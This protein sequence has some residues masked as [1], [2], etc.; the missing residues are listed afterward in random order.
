MANTRTQRAGR[1]ALGIAAAMALAGCD[2]TL[3]GPAPDP[4]DVTPRLACGE[5]RVTEIRIDGDGFSPMG[6]DT[7]TDAPHLALPQVSLTRVAALDGTAVAGEPPVVVPNDAEAPAEARVRWTDRTVLAFDVFPELALTPGLYEARVANPNG[8]AATLA[9]ALVIVPRPLLDAIEPD[10]TCTE[11]G[12]R[13]F[14]I[15]GSHFLHMK[16]TGALPTVTVRSETSGTVTVPIES[17]SDCVDLPGRADAALCRSGAL[18]LPQGAPDPSRV[19][20]LA[21]PDVIDVVVTNPDPGGCHSEDAVTLALVPPPALDAITPDLA[22]VAQGARTLALSGTNL[23]TVGTDA[24]TVRI[25]TLE[26]DATDPAGCVDVAG[27]LL[28]A[29]ACT[30]MN[31]TVPQDGLA[32]GSY[33]VVL[34]NPEPA[35]CFSEEARTVAIVPPPRLDSVTEDLMCLDEAD[36]VITLAGEGFVA[37]GEVLPI[38]RVGALALSADAVDGCAAIAGTLLP[39]TTCTT[40]TVTLPMDALEPGV[41]EVTVTNPDPAGCVSTEPVTLV[42]A[43]APTVVDVAP[44]LVCTAEGGAVVTVTGTDFLVVDGILPTVRVGETAVVAQDASGC[45]PVEGTLRDVDRCTT[46]TVLIPEGDPLPGAW[47]VSVENPEPA[48]C[49]SVQ[50]VTLAVVPPPAVTAVVP[51]VVCAT[52]QVPTLAIEGTG[53]LVVGGTNPTVTIDEVPV[54]VL[55]VD[56]CVDVAGTALAAQACGRIT[57][58]MPAGGLALGAHDVAVINPDP[59]PCGTVAEAGFAVAPAPTVTGVEPFKVCVNDGHFTVAGTD[60]FPGSA[61]LLDGPVDV[62][63]T[64]VSGTEL[65]GDVDGATAGLYDVTV[66]NGPGCE[67]TLPDALLLVDAPV[68]FF[69]DPPVVYNGISLQVTIHASGISGAVQSVGLRPAGTGETPTPLAFVHDLARPNRVLAVIPEGTAPGV[70]DVVLVDE[71]CVAVLETAVT[72]SDTLAVDVAAIEPVF[73][74]T[75]ARTAVTIRATEPPATGWQAFLPTPR[76]YLN[77]VDGGLETRASELRAVAYVD[78][79]TLTG[80]VPEGLPVGVYDLV[81]INPD[82]GVGL[83]PEAFRVT[84]DP[85]PDVSDLSPRTVIN[86]ELQSVTVLGQDFRDVAE[87]RAI[88]R[89]AGGAEQVVTAAISGQTS[90]TVSTVWNFAGL[91]GGEICVVR[92]TNGDGTWV[93][94]SALSVTNPSY[95]LNGFQ[96][97]T[98]MVAAR[99]AAAGATIRVNAAARYVFA[100]GGDAGAGQSLWDSVEAAPVDPYGD[101]GA[102]SLQRNRLPAGRAFAGASV[103]GRF[104]YLVGGRDGAGVLS[105][106]LRAFLLDPLDG[107]VVADLEMALK[108]DG[109][110]LAG[111]VWYYRIAPVMTPEYAANPGGEGLTGEPLIVQLPDRSPDRVA[112]TLYWPP[113]TGAAAYRVYRTAS[114]GQ[115]FGDER[116]LATIPATA[117]PSFVDDGTGTVDP[118]ASPLPAGSLGNW[119]EVG[120]LA[121]A[122]EGHAVAVARDPADPTLRYVYACGGR[123][124]VGN[125]HAS[126]EGIA[127]ELLGADDQVVHGPFLA[128]TVA[129]PRWLC[130]SVAVDAVAASVVPDGETWLYVLPGQ[131]GTGATVGEVDAFRVAAGGALDT[132]YAVT[133]INSGYAGYATA[134]GNGFLYL[135]GGQGAPTATGHSSQLCTGGGS[136]CSAGIPN[137]PDLTNWNAGQS[138]AVPRYLHAGSVESSFIFLLGGQTSTEAATRSTERTNM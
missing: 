91:T 41:Y 50:D 13:P 126:C 36:R 7:A 84:A 86:K 78:A 107:P 128:G 121:A 11:Q 116:L 2:G 98:D 73:G 53:F 20:S 63:T 114:P 76:A 89:T 16:G 80:V 28:D 19:A 64:Y 103:I 113:V 133:S 82:G 130:R 79:Y 10:L 26:L 74:W 104:V 97:A 3:S 60:F 49:R 95:N 136:G 67:G 59:A 44:D 109:V 27:T 75:E 90:G 100:I 65:A 137:P 39:A 69:V 71:L 83:L 135:F 132:R 52:A 34:T 48:G 70:Y 23:V 54:T 45:E 15:R 125:T 9:A 32:P 62:D 131:S 81:V 138:L 85:P 87:V 112:L 14:V 61:I 33:G 68:V 66:S 99:R 117:S 22:C 42:V 123:D 106:I 17:L 101:P 18:T 120:N 110:G 31:V 47:V 58:E 108:K 4:A 129:T 122:R 24:P 5:Q 55:D 105:S 40:L 57:V 8:N 119:H 12:A 115:I 21:N 96:V 118:E 1:L 43:P 77:P 124:G 92:V 56:Q 46:L 6:I 127:V 29:S 102:W 37:V 35:G 134:A 72:V 111:G 25:G 93:D 51:P 88:C 38:V 30:G 94:F